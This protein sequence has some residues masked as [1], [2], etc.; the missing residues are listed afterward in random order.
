MS[1]ALRHTD[2]ADKN[3]SSGIPGLDDVLGGGFPRGHFFL[4][5]GQPGAGKTTLGL[6]FLLDGRDRGESVLYVTLSESEQELK[7]VAA[8]HGWSLD[9]ITIYEFMPTEE[10]LR[11]EQQYSAFHPSDVEFRDSMQNILDQAER[12][13]P[14]RIVLDSLSEIRLLAAD[15]LRYRRQILALKTFFTSRGCTVLLLDDR[16]ISM[17]D[18]QLE[19][20]AH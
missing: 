13:R 14:A 2:K 7:K 20:I 19:S 5:E 1:K 9:G 11:P 17:Q 3:V 16:T 6:Q 18:G 10:A 8:S 15:A 12:A 4:V